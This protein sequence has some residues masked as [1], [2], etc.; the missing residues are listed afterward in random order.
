MSQYIDWATEVAREA[1]VILLRF[2]D[3]RVRVEYKSD[4]GDAD[5]VTEADR[6]SERHIIERLRG[7]FP[8]HDIVAEE[9]GRRDTGSEYR[10]Y[11]DPL[12]GTTNFSQRFPVVCG[13]MGL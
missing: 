12:D 3:S 6:T 1:G 9:S 13:A 4:A 10:W 11:I 5:L 7:R 2:Y 8:D